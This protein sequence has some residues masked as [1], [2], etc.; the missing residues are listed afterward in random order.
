[1][2]TG[3]RRAKE[4]WSK[5]SD[6][7]EEVEDGDDLTEFEIWR[8][9]RQKKQRVGKA[10]DEFTRFINLP[11]DNTKMPV[12]QWWLQPS[13]KEAYPRLQK[14]AIDVL[15]AP[16]TSADSERVFSHGRRVIPWTRASL[17]T[18]T[19]EE[20]LCMKY[21]I[22]SGLIDEQVDLEDDVR[23]AEDDEWQTEWRRTTR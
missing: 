13:Q 16:A 3:I 1:M 10:N 4:L 17:A 8:L 12:L 9:N 19:I 22:M 5:Y 20:I 21:W 6:S 11:A 14:M 7:D 18:N 23:V 2:A 15:T